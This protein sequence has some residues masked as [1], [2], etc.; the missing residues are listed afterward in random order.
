M[1]TT[2]RQVGE[3]GAGDASDETLASRARA[4]DRGAFGVLVERYGGRVRRYAL[5][6]LRDGHDA[7]EV[8]QETLLR[9]WRSILTY[10]EGEA[11]GAW[12]MAIARR[13]IVNVIRRRKKSARDRDPAERL[14]GRGGDDETSD[15]QV[16]PGTIWETAR[17][18]LG[19]DA[20][21]AVWLRYV[22]D[23]EP[24][25]IARVLGRSRV[26]VRVLLHRARRTLQ[27]RL[28]GHE[29]AF[30]E[31]EPELNG[32]EIRVAAREVICERA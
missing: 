15:D 21:E 26:G 4:G 19:D 20:F 10:R 27:A 32:Q 2:D 29:T 18:A 24:G 9:A 6:R 3:I 7:D 23:M 30:Q 1:T 22:E 5:A 12:V 14:H 25:Q 13:E 16:A 31:E 17:E 28:E 11:F 8:A